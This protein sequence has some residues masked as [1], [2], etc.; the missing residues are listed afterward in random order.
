[1]TS[2]LLRGGRVASPTHP[3]ATAL[4]TTGGTVGWVGTDADA[5]DADHTHDLAGAWVAPA[6]VDSHVHAT[7]TGLALTGLDL[8]GT[9]SLAA[10]LD[11]VADNARKL[12]GRPILG[13]GWD[14]TTWPERRPPTPAELDRASYGGVVF[15]ARV[16]HHSAVASSALLAAAPAARELTGW[17][18]TGHV[19]LA[20]HH[21]VRRTA[22]ASITAA[23]RQAAQRACRQHAASLGIAC[24]QEM[25]GPQITGGVV[26]LET[27]LHLAGTEDGP[28]V[29]AYWGEL[30][31][32][33]AAEPGAALSTVERLGLAGAAG[34]LFCDGSLGSHTAA[35]QHP[36]ADAPDRSGHHWHD[37]RAVAGHLVACTKAGVQ[38]GF[39]AIGDAAIQTILDGLAL[40]ET[41]VGLPALRAVRHRIEHAEVLPRGGVEAFARYGLVA[42]VQP[43][44]DAAWGG[45]DGMYAQRLGA[46]R[47]RGMNPFA[48]FLDQG[49]P[50]ALGSDSPVTP[51][52]PWGGVRAATRHRTA[53][54]SIPYA[55][56]LDAATRGGW[57]AAGHDGGVLAP[58]APATYAVWDAEFDPDRPDPTCLRTVLRGQP[59]YEG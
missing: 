59:I 28:Q 31:G 50:L 30:D 24:L 21:E 9:P 57:A 54:S 22:Y 53:A 19:R 52:D 6:F 8:S 23:Q 29:I 32:P 36:Y 38:G 1:M 4:L 49:V 34:D 37:A 26:D 10:A 12:R 27:L 56:A 18:E 25:S 48:R 14:D 46:E 13:T 42:S 41:E 2:T 44:F 58:G 16:D 55:A 39:H 35:L 3:H 11:A 40:A 17:S 15:L 47:A 7:Q 33:H 43:A 51:L 20:A 5:P 45:P